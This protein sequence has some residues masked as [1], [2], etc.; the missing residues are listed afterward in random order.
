MDKRERIRNR[1]GKAIILLGI[2]LCFFGF[3]N[4]EYIAEAREALE[5]EEI[6]EDAPEYATSLSSGSWLD[7]DGDGQKEQIIYKVLEES[8]TG[9]FAWKVRLC[10]RGEAG[11]TSKILEGEGLWKECFTASVGSD[12]YL[13]VSDYGDSADYISTFYRYDNGRLVEAGSMRSHPAAILLYPDRVTGEER[14]YHFQTQEIE[15]EYAFEKG[16]LINQE[17]DY[18]EYAQ[19]IVT[20]KRKLVLYAEKDAGD[21]AV[22]ISRDDKVRVMGGDLC[23]WVQLKKEST[24]EMGWLKVDQHS[25]CFLS[26]GTEIFA[27]DLFEDIIMY[28]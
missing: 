12:I 13:V 18:Y 7:L 26:D 23:Q 24:G 27:G 15:K 9:I 11:E 4:A 17:K 25:K 14:E 16:K 28:D 5:P 3:M 1:E 21:A 2:V 10:V 20:A 6:N 22:R 19:N 8:S